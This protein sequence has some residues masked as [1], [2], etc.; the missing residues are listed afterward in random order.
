MVRQFYR[1]G[2]LDNLQFHGQVVWYHVQEAY[3]ALERSLEII[4]F[5]G[6]LL[7]EGEGEIKEE[8]KEEEKEE[9]KEEIKEE[10]KDDDDDD[11]FHNVDNVAFNCKIIWSFL[12]ALFHLVDKFLHP[13]EDKLQIKDEEEEEE[14]ENKEKKEEVRYELKYLEEI[15]L[16]KNEFT[17][18]WEQ[19]KLRND[20]MTELADKKQKEMKSQ[21]N[22]INMEVVRKGLEYIDMDDLVIYEEELKESKEQKKQQIFAEINDLRCQIKL[23]EEKMSSNTL[24]IEAKEEAIQFVKSQYVDGL[25]NSFIIEKTPLG[26]VLMYYNS[27]RGS[28]EY[29]SDNTIPYRYLETVS[30]KYVKTFNCR[31]LY[32]DMDNEISLAEKKLKEVLEKKALE[33]EEMK[34]KLLE[35]KENQV[36]SKKDVF[37]KFKSYNKDSGTGRVNTS[38]PPKN[39]IPNARTNKATDNSN[40]ILKDNANRYTCEGRLSNFSFLKKTKREVVD[41]KYAMSFADFKKLKKEENKT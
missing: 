26:N 27:V 23:L 9:E 34:K 13:P 36:V 35:Q 20:K 22:E 6:P 15:K 33:E 7:E 14:E 18:T 28:F 10:E 17:C 3:D 38:A 5:G 11:E 16:L 37:A 39:S 40:V 21:I 29:Y 19:L 32:V 2:Y 24:Q 1:K 8:I 4:N 30:R 41:K 25:K 31:Y 12:R